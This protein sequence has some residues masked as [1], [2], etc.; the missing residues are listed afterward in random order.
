MSVYYGLLYTTF[1]LSVRHT[2]RLFGLRVEITGEDP[3]HSIKMSL[4]SGT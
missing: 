4:F 3:E 1:S 2:G